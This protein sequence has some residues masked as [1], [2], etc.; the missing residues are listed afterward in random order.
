M[1]KDEEMYYKALRD[2][3]VQFSDDGYPVV[4]FLDEN[5]EK[6]RAELVEAKEIDGE[7]YVLANDLDDEISSYILMEKI[8]NDDHLELRSID[9]E[10]EFER[11]SEYFE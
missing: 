2:S 4:E 9:D 11:I 3:G 6:V 5:G 8:I 10:E 7:T 1:D